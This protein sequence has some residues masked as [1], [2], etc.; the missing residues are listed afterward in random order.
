[1][2]VAGAALSTVICSI[3]QLLFVAYAASKIEVEG[4]V[5]RRWNRPEILRAAR[6]GVPLG[7]QMGAEVGIFAL[8]G[9][10]ASRLGTM[11]LAA[12]QLTIGLASF[13]FTIALG[14]ASAGSVRVGNAIGARN[15]RG[16]R[17]AGHAAFLAGAVVMG[18]SG[19]A[20]AFFP[21]AIIRIVTNQENVIA[22]ALPL[23]L[24]AA[25]FQL[26]DGI[27]AVGAGVLRG[28]GDTHY[29]FV[30][31]VIGHWAIGF[32]IALLLGFTFHLGIVG[33]WWG[34]C[35]GLTVVAVLLVL[36]FEKLS[37][38]EIRPI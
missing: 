17:I 36:R 10:I 4:V 8:V 11:P 29:A 22:A 23:M 14:V 6:V 33:R 7:L 2:G 1:M 24:V 35:V 12:H 15:V 30:A 26:S 31:N 21:R 13:T 37:R 3:F 34:L 5:D 32:P 16:T 20:F 19:L 18:I 9:V 27:Q 25:V 28:A 38:G